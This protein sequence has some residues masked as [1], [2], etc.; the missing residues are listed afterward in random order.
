M[1]TR[2]RHL[3]GIIP[4]SWRGNRFQMP[5]PDCG[6][7][8]G[9]N[10]YAY[11]NSVIECALAGCNTI[12]IVGK[13]PDLNYVRYRV[14]EYAIDPAR[15]IN[16]NADDVDK[17]GAK[18]PI[19]YV[20][21]NPYY[22]NRF[23]NIYWACLHGAHKAHDL[24]SKWSSKVAPEKFY[25]SFPYFLFYAKPLLHYRNYDYIFSD[26]NFLFKDLD[27]DTLFYSTDDKR[28]NFQSAALNADEVLESYKNVR[29]RSTGEI[30]PDSDKTEIINGDEVPN[31]KYDPDEQWSA[32][33]WGPN[34]MF[35]DVEKEDVVTN[36]VDDLKDQPFRWDAHVRTWGEHEVYM[37]GDNRVYKSDLILNNRHVDTRVN[38]YFPDEDD[39]ETN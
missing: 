1:K 14:G 32:K 34:D 5:N 19:Y 22:Y 9:K 39:N 30:K 24:T 4:V 17:Y 36:E 3:A 23:F 29:V 37:K 6:L 25:F 13:K 20:E 12:W 18:R 21:I 16:L 35:R 33:K 38:Y 8:V 11:E 28:Q 2:G 26:K 31:E 7:L 10:I 27:G 15:M